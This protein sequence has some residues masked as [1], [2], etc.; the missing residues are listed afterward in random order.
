MQRLRKGYTRT[1]RQELQS[2]IDGLSKIRSERFSKRNSQL[3]ISTESTA[4]GLVRSLGY[5]KE[6]LE[7]KYPTGRG[8][9]PA[10]ILTEGW[11]L[12]SGWVLPPTLD[13]LPPLPGPIPSHLRKPCLV[14]CVAKVPWWSNGQAAPKTTNGF[15]ASRRWNSRDSF[16]WC[17]GW[18][19]GFWVRISFV[20][21]ASATSLWQ[22]CVQN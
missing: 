1:W 17:W 11:Y 3:A 18:S 8:D 13:S 15:D 7:L 21:F 5:P 14:P 10:R 9:R 20:S 4:L 2:A 6:N 16:I 12:D 19:S 22:D